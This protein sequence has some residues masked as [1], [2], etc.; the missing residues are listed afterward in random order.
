MVLQF[1]RSIRNI[2]NICITSDKIPSSIASDSCQKG[3]LRRKEAR[4]HFHE[5]PYSA[6]RN[7]QG[8]CCSLSDT[9]PHR[10]LFVYCNL[11][12]QRKQKISLL[13]NLFLQ[14]KIYEPYTIQ[15]SLIANLLVKNT[16]MGK[17]STA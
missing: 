17:I 15:N 4:M 2:Y 10:L 14:S 16:N 11:D 12:M 6:F 13:S 3:L 7:V 1:C 9:S 8:E 5:L